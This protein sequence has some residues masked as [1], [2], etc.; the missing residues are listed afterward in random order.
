MKINNYEGM[1]ILK[2]SLE[3]AALKKVC[4]NIKEVMQKKEIT[5]VKEE[6]WPKK[7]MTFSI[8]KNKEGIYYVLNFKGKSSAISEI[9]KEYSLNDDI[10]RVLIFTLEK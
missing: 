3:E 10:L 6:V 7:K 5:I 1:F 9:K 4:D 8:K 2:P